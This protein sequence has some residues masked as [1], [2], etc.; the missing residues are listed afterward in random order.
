MYKIIPDTFAFWTQ[1][2]CLTKTRCSFL[3][4]KYGNDMTNYQ[5]SGT[6]FNYCNID[7]ND[8]AT[9]DIMDD[10]SKAV[11]AMNDLFY[12]YDITM[13][14]HLFVCKFD[15]SSHIDLDSDINYQVRSARKFT[16]FI[17]L[18]DNY[19]E[20]ETVVHFGRKVKPIGKTIGLMTMIPAFVSAEH[21]SPPGD[22]VKHVLMGSVIGPPFK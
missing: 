22:N 19:Y 3:V 13:L 12:Q 16:F 7:T 4:D 18:S 15:S 10:C 1:I 17:P 6:N 2:P 9:R 8:L 20:G 5:E 14:E 11:R 21:Q